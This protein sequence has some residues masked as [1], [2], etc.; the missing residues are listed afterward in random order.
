MAIQFNPFVKYKGL[1]V[2]GIVEMANGN[3]LT[4]NGE[5]GTFEFVDDNKRAV[6]Q[7]GGE[8]LYRFLKD[9]QL[10]LGFKYNLV[11]GDFLKS[12][13]DRI[14]VAAGWYPVKNLL[15]KAEYVQ[16]RYNDF[17]DSDRLYEGEFSGVVIEAVVGF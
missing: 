7:Y 3:N 2:F 6:N 4:R 9:E 1:E 10:Y 11:T 5:T 14:E 16:Q 17:P 13:I 15:L 12:N 8:I